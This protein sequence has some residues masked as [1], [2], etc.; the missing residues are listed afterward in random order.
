MSQPS[1]QHRDLEPGEALEIGDEYLS[2]G[3]WKTLTEAEY[4]KWVG[5][6]SHYQPGE[7]CKFRRPLVKASNEARRSDEI[8]AAEALRC[9]VLPLRDCF[10]RRR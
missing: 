2:E 7:M 5:F 1:P 10:R 6:A 8:F 3:Q 4:E 9:A